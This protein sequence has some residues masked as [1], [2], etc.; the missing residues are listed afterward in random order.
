[1]L[2]QQ[3]HPGCTAVW[4]YVTCDMPY[5]VYCMHCAMGWYQQAG[6]VR[7]HACGGRQP[8]TPVGWLCQ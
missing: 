8:V 1:M 6:Q 5:T 7:S 4:L 3:W 2:K